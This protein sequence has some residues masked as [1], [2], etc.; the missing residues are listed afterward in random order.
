MCR[1]APSGQVMKRKEVEGF[2]TI[3][4]LH[5]HRIIPS[6]KQETAENLTGFF[7]KFL[8][9]DCKNLYS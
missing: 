6:I 3:V 4:E 1:I 5:C 7:G 2:Q 9:L 8:A